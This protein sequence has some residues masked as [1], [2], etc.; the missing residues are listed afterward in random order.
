MV[1]IDTLKSKFERCFS[2]VIG[3]LFIHHLYERKRAMS[4][5]E[6][7]N[8]I[9]KLLKS[10]DIELLDFVFQLLKRSINPSLVETHQRPA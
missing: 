10:A 3:L 5:T 8:A 1:K 6:Y 2:A 9:T 7:I 4:R